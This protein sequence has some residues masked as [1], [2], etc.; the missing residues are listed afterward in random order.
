MLYA[1]SVELVLKG[2]ACVWASCVQVNSS[3][4]GTSSLKDVPVFGALR[5]RD[6]GE[7][8]KIA[9]VRPTYL[10]NGSYCFTSLQQLM[11]FCGL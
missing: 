8:Q 10:V 9:Q 2:T 6:S 7:L 11:I 3:S 1:G 5:E 4:G